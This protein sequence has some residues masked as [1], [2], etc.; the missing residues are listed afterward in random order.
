MACTRCRLP[1]P[2]DLLNP[3]VGNFPESG[4]PVCGI[5]ALAIVNDAH[6]AEMTRFQGVAEQ[7][8]QRALRWRRAHP[9]AEPVAR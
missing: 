8:R 7:F 6:G 1:Y 5:C 4:Q 3:V 2:D 9:H